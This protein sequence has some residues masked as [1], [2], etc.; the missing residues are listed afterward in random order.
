MNSTGLVL[1]LPEAVAGNSERPL[2]ELL[3][4][5]GTGDQQAFLQLYQQISPKVLGT[6][7][8][9]VRT[10]NVCGPEPSPV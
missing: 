7:R 8:S 5:I 10:E 2:A 4:L 3:Q 1:S 6:A 9:I